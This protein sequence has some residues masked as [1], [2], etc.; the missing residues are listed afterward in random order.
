MEANDWRYEMR[1]E[2][3]EILPGLWLG[4]YQCSKDLETLKSRRI[5][6]I[7]CIR[8]VNERH[9]MKIR[10]PEDFTYHVIEVS[11][12]PMQNL[13]PHFPEAKAFLDS[14]LAAGGKALVHC[15]SGISR[16]PAFVVAYLIMSQGWGYSQAYAFVQNKRFCIN[17]NEGFKYQLK[18]P[19]LPRVS[20]Y[21]WF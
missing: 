21:L 15:N 16:A 14:V 17:P 11:E 7:L 10:F 2:M 18:V 5:T 12:S 20:P 8:D 13:I 4:P 3:Q 1:R 6:H 19:I 9:I